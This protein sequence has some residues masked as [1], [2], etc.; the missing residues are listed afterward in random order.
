M[1]KFYLVVF[2]V[3]TPTLLL[4][5]NNPVIDSVV[6]NYTTNQLTASG[7]NFSTSATVTFE[8]ASLTASSIT[9]TQFVVTLP[10]GLTAG[11]YLL[12]ITNTPG[13]TGQISVEYAAP[14]PTLTFQQLC[15]LVPTAASYPHAT[16]FS[17][18]GVGCVK[19]IFASSQVFDGNL[20]GS[21]GADQKCQQLATA[22]G[23]P[24]Q[25]KSYTNDGMRSSPAYSSS[26]N[27]PFVVI[28]GDYPAGP[29]LIANAEEFPSSSI[30]LVNPIGETEL[31]T[32]IDGSLVWT[33]LDGGNPTGYDCQ[34]WT[35]NLHSD[36]GT[37][38]NSRSVD[39][40]WSN[41]RTLTCDTQLR[42]YCWQQ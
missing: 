12:A 21:N 41:Y 34:G 10:T 31:Q 23:L 30:S 4:A 36:A 9:S 24:G 26:P 28:G 16:N 40:T 25:Y 13:Q 22:S 2:I 29:T 32:H 38:G 1:Q 39:S 27:V 42:L 5:V 33:G 6:I 8:G 15:S 7:S 19:L 11:A 35:S 37:V 17:Q 14:T 18:A 20:G 3:L